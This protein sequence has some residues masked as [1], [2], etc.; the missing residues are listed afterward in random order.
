MVGE[1]IEENPEGVWQVI[2]EFGV[3]EDEDMRIAVATVLLEHLLEYHFTTYFPRLEE[4][5]KGGSSLLAD[6]LRRCWAFGRAE[7]HWNEV[8]ALLDH[9]EAGQ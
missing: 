1:S 5:I 9:Y 7:A 6:T 8:R 2:C 4:K 3:T